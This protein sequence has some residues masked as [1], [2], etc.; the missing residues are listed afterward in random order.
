MEVRSDGHDLRSCKSNGA[1]EC[2]LEM[3]TSHEIYSSGTQNT[4][5]TMETQVLDVQINLTRSAK[6][7]KTKNRIVG[8]DKT[9]KDPAEAM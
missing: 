2:V 8:E 6:Y 9:V 1:I 5:I 3:I 7:F 4:L